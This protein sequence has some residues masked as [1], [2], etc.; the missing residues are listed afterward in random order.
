VGTLFNDEVLKVV[1]FGFSAGQEQSAHTAPM[2]AVPHFL[3]GKQ[4]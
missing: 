3:K 2:A 1:A 4:S